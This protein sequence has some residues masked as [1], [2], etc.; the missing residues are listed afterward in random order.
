M[1]WTT[2]VQDIMKQR[3]GRLSKICMQRECAI[4]VPHN[5][6]MLTHPT[7]P[8]MAYLVSC[9]RILIRACHSA[10]EVLISNGTR[11]VISRDC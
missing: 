2:Q 8:P 11:L 5:L 7:F 4:V 6:T 9:L 10:A 1:G 3:L